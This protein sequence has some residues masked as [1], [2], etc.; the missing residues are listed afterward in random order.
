MANRCVTEID[1]AGINQREDALQSA[2]VIGHSNAGFDDVGR[3]KQLG[4][5]R[6]HCLFTQLQQI[7]GAR[8][9]A[10]CTRQEGSWS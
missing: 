7:D 4:E 2:D 3:G 6:Q 9:V 8:A 5:Q 10:S 1:H